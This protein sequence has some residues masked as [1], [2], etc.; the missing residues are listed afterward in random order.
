MTRR[1]GVYLLHFDTPYQHT[2]HYCGWG[3][4]VV[5][6][7]ESQLKGKRTAAHFVKVVHKAGIKIRLAHIWHGKDRKFERKLK[8]THNLKRFCPICKCVVTVEPD[9]NFYQE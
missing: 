1:Q 8:D 4:N 7:V 9:V 6:R 5:M 2:R 3:K